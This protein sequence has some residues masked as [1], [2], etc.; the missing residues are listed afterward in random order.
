MSDRI[1]R[2]GS[3]AGFVNDSALGIAQLLSG[4]GDLDYVI[5]EYLA[6]G[7]MA[8]LAADE[9]R[10]PGS[11]F[12]PHLVDIHLGPHLA[13]ILDRGIKVITNAGGLNP[14]GQAA[15]IRRAAQAI[16]QYP[17]IAVVTGDDLRPRID[18]IRA[19]DPREFYSGKPLP[20][21]ITS[22]NAY[23]GAFPIAHALARGANIVVTGRNVDSAL[24]LGPLIHEFG[25]SAE[26]YDALA[27][28]TAAGHLLEC[29]AQA[30]GGTFTD[31]R[32]VPDW[33][34]PGYPIAE[35]RAD[36]GFVL[37]KPAGS[38][39]LVSVGT[40]SEQ[41]IYEVQD[42]EAYLVPDVACDF[43][44]AIVRQVSP[45]RVD[46]SGIGG[47][48]PTASYKVAATFKD[49]WR[50]TA[51]FAVTGFDAAERAAHMGDALVRRC[52][53]M[54]RD[55]N[56][57]DFADIRV[58]VLGSEASLAGRTTRHDS[59]EVVCRIVARHA[60]R[61]GAELIADEGRSVM[62]TMAQGSTGLG[63][64]T[65]APVLALYSFLL[66]KA[67]VPISLSID[68]GAPT[69]VPI[70]SGGGFDSATLARPRFPA[71]DPDTCD[72]TLPLIALA[73]ARSGDKADM[74][75]IGVIARDP[76]YL[77]YL[78][79]ALTEHRIA[80]WFSHTTS[81]GQPPRV[82]RYD[83]PGFHCINLIVFDALGGG[84]TSGMRFDPN[85]KGMGQ[86]L[87]AIDIPLPA[88]LADRARRAMG[89]AGHVHL[90]S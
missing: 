4:G 87:L 39:G 2:I 25:W 7:I 84:Q 6:E 86:Q 90:L 60:D 57:A 50:A 13:T 32:Q 45:D 46:V 26:D 16:G 77:P 19:L 30:T 20:D 3:G 49:G 42:V 80:D 34:T 24:T 1:I 41:L 88:A 69:P 52:R 47:R 65:V 76:V 66:D 18:E 14:H 58:D 61:A 9:E 44:T 75:N 68:N 35:C 31:W 40:V 21:D 82:E 81:N 73:W 22:I 33:A 48:A 59:R 8:W 12:S 27:G 89:S 78:S 51:L 17:R 62:T 54:L 71:A 67:K 37:T 70:T 56:L 23:L 63:P 36:G 64:A 79:A 5:F 74:F 53:L 28:G 15:A 38:G 85:A 72:D 10:E 55:R 43:S 29:G 11:G 83:A